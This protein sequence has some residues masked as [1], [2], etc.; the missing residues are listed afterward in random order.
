MQIVVG[1]IQPGSTQKFSGLRELMRGTV[2]LSRPAHRQA[3]L[4]LAHLSLPLLKAADVRSG[5]VSCC[6][7]R[8]LPERL[9]EGSTRGS[10]SRGM[11]SWEALATGQLSLD[12]G[13]CG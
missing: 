2:P 11:E 6:E 12:E 10:S 8:L 7:W 3:A 1:L 4:C 9:T 5:L 13:H